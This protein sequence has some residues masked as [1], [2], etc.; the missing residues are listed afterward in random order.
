M[1]C[2]F[3]GRADGVARI[4]EC[5]FAVLVE[6]QAGSDSFV[7]LVPALVSYCLSMCLCVYVCMRMFV[8]L[9]DLGDGFCLSSSAS[10]I[11]SM[12][13]EVLL[14]DSVSLIIPMS[15]VALARAFFFVR[16]FLM[17]FNSCRF[18]P[19]CLHG[20]SQNSA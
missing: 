10:E 9:I 1:S 16:C 11:P 15:Y 17:F 7:S 6:W 5:V 2:C 14:S 4:D 8:F 13:W 18:Y 20:Y 19:H 12:I 3:G